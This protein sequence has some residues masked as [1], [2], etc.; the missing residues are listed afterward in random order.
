MKTIIGTV[1]AVQP[2]AR[3]VTVS[4]IVQGPG[5]RVARTFRVAWSGSTSFFSKSRRRTRSN[6]DKLRAGSRVVLIARP[7]PGGKL[8]ATEVWHPTGSGVLELTASECRN[9]GGTV[10]NDGECPQ[11]GGKRRCKTAG[12]SMCITEYDPM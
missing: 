6:A 4:A 8:L 9:L 3:S 10:T 7:G 12:G 2:G 11:L 5:G 1:E